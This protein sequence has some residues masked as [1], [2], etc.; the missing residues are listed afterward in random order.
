MPFICPSCSISSLIID[1]SIELSPD[2]RSDEISIQLVKCLECNFI[3]LAIYE[4][5]RR[6][7]LSSESLHHHG[8]Y[9]ANTLLSSIKETIESCP[10]PKNS[11]CK[12]AAHCILNQVNEF[13]R[14]SWLEN[15]S[16]IKEFQMIFKSSKRL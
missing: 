4:E 11:K 9:V 1:S 2:S 6:G 3:G 8:Y 10:D 12:C 13:G 14:W 7:S 16:L 15:V 5:S